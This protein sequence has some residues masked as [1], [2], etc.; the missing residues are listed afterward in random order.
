MAICFELVVNFGENIDGARS[1][2]LANPSPMTLQAGSH[3][4]PLHRAL[5]NRSGSCIEL[6]VI[7]VA[8]G[9]G[10]ALD[11]TL[12]RT[13]LTA[14]ELTELGAGLYRLLTGF[15]GYLTAKVGWDPEGFLDPEELQSDWTDDLADGTI[16]GLVLCDALHG[17]LGLGSNYVEFQPGYQWIPYQGEKQSTLTAD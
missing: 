6:S 17:E 5:I 8:V 11:G 9:W 15:S 2:A 10:V 16:D 14:A 4:V 13:R 12:P 1:A 3:R 7:P